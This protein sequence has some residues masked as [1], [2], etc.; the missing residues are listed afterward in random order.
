MRRTTQERAR[1]SHAAPPFLIMTDELQRAHQRLKDALV[2]Y[3]ILIGF[4]ALSCLGPRALY[5][6]AFDVTVL[7]PVEGS[8]VSGQFTEAQPFEG[9]I[10]NGNVQPSASPN[11][12]LL[13]SNPSASALS[14]VMDVSGALE[15]F[16]QPFQSSCPDFSFGDDP[17][18]ACGQQGYCIFTKQCGCVEDSDC[19]S[20]AG[21]CRDDGTCGCELDEH[22]GPGQVCN[23]D[24]SCSCAADIACSAGESCLPS[25]VCSCSL[26]ED[27]GAGLV[28]SGGVCSEL[29][30]LGTSY[31]DIF[32]PTDGQVVSIPFPPEVNDG[33]ALSLNI[34]VTDQSSFSVVGSAN[35]SFELDRDFPLINSTDLCSADPN[36]PEGDFCQGSCDAGFVCDPER[37]RCVSLADAQL[38]PC[39]PEDDFSQG[40]PANYVLVDDVDQSPSFEFLESIVDG[41]LTTQRLLVKDSCGNAQLINLDSQRAPTP[42][43]VSASLSAYRCFNDECDP[44]PENALSSGALAGRAIISPEVVA[45]N[46]CYAYADATLS[47]LDELG[48]ALLNAQGEPIRELLFSDEVI[49]ARPASVISTRLIDNGFG[50]VTLVNGGVFELSDGMVLRVDVSG[51]SEEITFRSED[52]FDITEAFAISVIQVIND[53]SQL[54][55]AYL[56]DTALILATKA[57]GRDVSLSLSG[58]AAEPLGFSADFDTNQA[59]GSGDGRYQANLEVYACNGATPIASASFDLEIEPLQPISLGGPYS[60]NQGQALTVSAV[61]AVSSDFGGI[62]YLEWDSDGDGVYEPLSRVDFDPPILALD[63]SLGQG[64]AIT[65]DTNESQSFLVKLRLGLGSGE[66]REAQAGVEIFDVSP[67]CVAPSVTVNGL[68]TINIPVEATVIF[69]ASATLPGHESDPIVSYEWDFGDGTVNSLSEP[70]ATHVYE[71]EGSYTVQL[72]VLDID[73]GC[74]SPVSLSVLVVGAQPIIENIG[75]AHPET[76]LIE[77]EPIVFTAGDTR[78]GAAEDPINSYTWTFGYS[79][80]SGLVSASAPS[81][82]EPSHTFADDGL[83][84]ICLTVEDNDDTA[85]P[86]C[87]EIEV[88]DLEPRAALDG[89]TLITEGQPA[90]FDATGSLAGG[91]ADPLTELVWSFGDGTTQVTSPDTLTVTHLYESDSAGGHYTVTLT[92][93]DEDSERSAEHRVQVLDVSPSS[94]FAFEFPNPEFV[95]AYEGVELSLDASASAPGAPSDQ[96]VAY[97]WDFGDGESETTSSPSV[98]HSWPDG[99]R[100]YQVS[101]TVEDSDG[102]LSVT[103][104][105]LSVVNVAPSIEISYDSERV[106]VGTPI[107]FNLIVDDVAGDRPESSDQPVTIEWD[108]GDDSAYDSPSV[109]H[110]FSQEGQ[111]LIRARYVDGDTGEAEA[112]LS[113]TVAP[114]PATVSAPLVSVTDLAG[115]LI[116]DPELP[117]GSYSELSPVQGVYYLREGERLSLA[118]NI[119]S[120]QLSNGGYDSANAVWS[121]SPDGAELS[122]EPL[123]PATGPNAGEQELSARLDWSP[124]YYQAGQYLL[125]LSVEGEVT[126]SS[127]L[128][129]WR[130]IVVEAGSPMLAATTGSQ[131]RGRVLLYRYDRVNNE[132]SFSPNRE[133]EVGLGAY[134]VIADHQRGRLFVSSPGSHHVSVLGGDPL[135]VIRQIPTG[136]SP[137]D[138]AW[139][140]GYLWVLE[141]GARSVSAISPTSLK[142]VR[143]LSLPGALNPQAIAWVG[144]EQGL[145][146]ARLFVGD[147]RNGKLYVINPE[148]LVAGLGEASIEATHQLGL[149]LTHIGAHD[150]QLVVTDGKR[151]ELYY[152]PLSDSPFTVSEQSSDFLSYAGVPFA[153]L[154]LL[155][156][157]DGLWL[158][159]G[160]ALWRLD[161]GP[162]PTHQA[163]EQ[164]ARYIGA[165]DPSALGG[166][167]YVIYDGFRLENSSFNGEALEPL[168]GLDGAS[169]LSVTPFIQLSDER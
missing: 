105:A 86:S 126:G 164:P 17:Y 1:D 121:V 91:E 55:S 152:A 9:G 110:I 163:L 16:A 161:L 45:P 145:A 138:M 64:S 44:A 103:S 66:L 147:A 30:S 47:P 56:E 118:V 129:E 77:G 122:Y 88:T 15:A 8:C 49:Q 112:E 166:P 53:Q 128:K 117:I 59:E 13:L 136:D 82:E 76:P 156:S 115:E 96:I 42:G 20:G 120:A 89:P 106:E 97:R 14:F 74:A 71:Q 7:S 104:Q 68:N 135:S 108:F 81:L 127:I 113:V 148:Q 2:S 85:G 168:I 11:A 92:V 3:L 125:R 37:S 27:C 48:Q 23:D 137:Y 75:L 60:V 51:Q 87:F 52:F 139:G 159:T 99:P 119:S 57:Y 26:D 140:G 90:T 67:S 144:P 158:A 62:S 58:S 36:C 43:E 95:A 69:D 19:D 109:T 32:D 34:E 38:G 41:C 169:V 84:Q 21:R 79:D 31:A 124:S 12:E 134:D 78:A 24:G 130:V 100:D 70:T 146:S 5:A 133:V 54:V 4:S 167:A 160:A 153:A 35:V 149:S 151:R 93:R 123:L 83:Y 141:A 6:Q 28:C 80:N 72:N 165:A 143:T 102:S 132:L 61:G 40:L 22:C 33:A 107:T 29:V 18:E 142:L 98:S 50:G 94:A 157:A 154:S 150:G 116:E 10:I 155:S 39:R 73:S 111:V 114:R 46:G 65:I 131:R 162:T 63:G 25:G 101:L